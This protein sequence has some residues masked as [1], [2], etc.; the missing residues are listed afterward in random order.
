MKTL[1]ILIAIFFILAG[2]ATAQF[3]T[4][5]QQQQLYNQQQQLWQ[6]RQMLN[7][8]KHQQIQQDMDNFQNQVQQYQQRQNTMMQM[9]METLNRVPQYHGPATCFIGSL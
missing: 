4:P 5:Y 2:S 3:M 8:M 7:Q 9:G 6:Q 1:I